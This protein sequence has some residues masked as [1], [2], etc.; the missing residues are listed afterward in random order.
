M[1]QPYVR[2]WMKQ[3]RAQTGKCLIILIRHSRVDQFQR[4]AIAN[5]AAADRDVM[6]HEPP[7]GIDLSD[8][9]RWRIRTACNRCATA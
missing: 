9:E 8:A 1:S 4:A 6:Q 7:T 2:Q 5:T 3:L